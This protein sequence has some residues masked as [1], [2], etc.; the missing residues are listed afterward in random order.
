MR[1]TALKRGSRSPPLSQTPRSAGAGG[2]LVMT[3]VRTLGRGR[4]EGGPAVE[5]GAEAKTR[6]EARVALPAPEPDLA[7]S[8]VEGVVGHD[9]RSHIGE[10][11]DLV[12]VLRRL[13]RAEE[14]AVALQVL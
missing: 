12:G 5:G 6:L 4:A 2:S 13:L 1:R 11:Q 14:G 3:T 10:A 7:L 8:G 9:H